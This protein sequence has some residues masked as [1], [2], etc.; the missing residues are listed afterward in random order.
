MY[1]Y[2]YLV[3]V[4]ETLKS[5]RLF[6]EGCQK[7]LHALGVMVGCHLGL[8]R[9]AQLIFV[10]VLAATASAAACSGRGDG[11]EI[12]NVAAAAQL[13][14]RPRWRPADSRATGRNDFKNWA[15]WAFPA[16]S[17]LLR[18]FNPWD[19]FFDILERFWTP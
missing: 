11:P 1:L 4:P 10:L 8:A 5:F 15:F 19:A 13:Q 16:F 9:A 6:G 7:L 12:R 18:R 14:W 17:N 2:P 3:L